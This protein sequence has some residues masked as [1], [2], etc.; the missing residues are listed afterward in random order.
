MLFRSN[1]ILYDLPYLIDTG[2]GTQ[3]D[4]SPVQ[5][6]INTVNMTAIAGAGSSETSSIM[7]RGTVS[8]N[9]GGT[10]IPQ[11]QYSA[12]P[13]IVESVIKGSWFCFT[14]VGAAGANVSIGTWA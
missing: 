11:M 10:F 13:T 14:P 8:I 12:T 6:V 7:L 5:V 3:V 9:T 4:A 1:N 2:T